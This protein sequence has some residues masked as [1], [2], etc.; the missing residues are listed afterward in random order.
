LAGQTGGWQSGLLHQTVNLA[1]D[2][3][4]GFESLSAH[5]RGCNSAVEFLPSKQ[6]V[7]GSNPV[8]RS[9]TNRKR[10]LLL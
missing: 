4:R 6:D 5:S 8:A 2:A 10:A 9:A 1:G 7:A 3:L